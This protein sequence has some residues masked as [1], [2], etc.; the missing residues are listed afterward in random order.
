MP[1]GPTHGITSPH[2]VVRCEG[3]DSAPII[4]RAESAAAASPLCSAAL[5]ASSAFDTSIDLLDEAAAVAA[6]AAAAA[7]A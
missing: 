4:A 2:E 7:A 1:S 6:A 5:R 3:D